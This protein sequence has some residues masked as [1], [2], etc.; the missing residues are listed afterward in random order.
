MRLPLPR[1]VRRAAAPRVDDF[2]VRR[3]R[4][5]SRRR[6]RS[7]VVDSATLQAVAR[8]AR[9]TARRGDPAGR[10]DEAIAGAFAALADADVSGRRASPAVR[11]TLVDQFHRLY[12]HSAKR[13]WQDTR[14]LGVPVWK[15]P[16]DLWIYQELIHELRPDVLIE[17]GTKFGGSAYYFARLFDLVGHGQ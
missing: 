3:Y 11:R 2:V 14:F 15:S 13:T 10:T 8:L 6:S 17:A 16:L 5:L 1:A 12:Y 4:A 7:E 9:R